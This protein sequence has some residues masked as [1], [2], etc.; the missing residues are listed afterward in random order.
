M[1]FLFVPWGLVAL[2]AGSIQAQESTTAEPF[3]LSHSAALKLGYHFYPQSDYFDTTAAYLDPQDFAGV[4][5]EIE[6]DYRWQEEVSLSLTLGYYDGKA[7][8]NEICCTRLKFSTTYFLIT[9]KYHILAL[10]LD[11]YLGAGI[12]YYLFELKQSGSIDISDTLST[13]LAGFHV[14]IGA[15]WLLTPYLS[16]FAEVRYAWAS[17]SSANSLDDSLGI[18]GANFALGAAYHFSGFR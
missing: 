16:T 1:L 3:Q 7:D 5:G 9:P 18:G 10:P 17:V 11:G 12:G 4:S 15:Q 6:Y 14:L 8:A 13:S 2:T